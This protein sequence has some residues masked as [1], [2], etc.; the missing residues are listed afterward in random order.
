MAAR[1]DH[2][3]I[4]AASLEQGV[5][6]AEAT[7]GVTPGPGGEHPLMG[8][9]NRLL[10]IA[11]VDYPRAY[12]EII[13]VQPGQSPQQGKRW[14]DLDAE[15]VRDTLRQ[16]G[17][18]LLHYVASVPD[19]RAAVAALQ[20]VGLDRGNVVQASRMTARGLLEWQITIRPDGQRLLDGTLP[21]LIEWGAT[22][23]AAGMGESGVTLHALL[24]QH[25]QAA[26]LRSAHEAIGLERLQVRQGP[27]N[28]CATL[29]TPR[30]R[31][32]L[33]SGGL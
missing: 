24:A 1:V 19:V 26:Q 18:R 16:G 25:P 4:G 2:L 30:G 12:L 10:R 14:F 31:V 28:L 33:E 21:T 7:L 9:H 29:D 32:Q 6:W 15:A 27:A 20:G 5:A 17:P 13:A 3:V 8:T 23:P 22:H 11:T